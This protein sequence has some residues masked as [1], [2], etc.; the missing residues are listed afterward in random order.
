M[1]MIQEFKEFAM[2]GNVVDMAVGVVIGTAFG[3][4]VKAFVE[5]MIMPLVGLLGDV[6][7]SKYDVLL[8][9]ADAEKGTEAIS[10]GVGTFV[11]VGINFL[12]VAFAIFLA[13]KFMNSVRKRFE[14]EKE[15]EPAKPSDEVVLLTEIRDALAKK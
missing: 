6:D 7:F 11:T 14:A 10:L 1:G 15:S 2:K 3:G 12:I 13:I 4:V 5:K 9:A 8:R